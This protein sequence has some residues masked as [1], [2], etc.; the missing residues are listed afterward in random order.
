[1]VQRRSKKN[2]RNLGR[3]TWAAGNKKNNRGAGSRGGTGRAGRKHKWTRIV[4]YEKERIGK[5]GFTR[6][7]ASKLNVI[8]LDLISEKIQKNKE[9]SSSIELNGYKVLSDGSLNK[10]ITIKA[11]AFSKKAIE[12]IKKAGG[13]AITI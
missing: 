9:E 13:D 11:N 5:P 6:W 7:N 8:N 12:K 3:R 4:K 2:R 1:M 10:P